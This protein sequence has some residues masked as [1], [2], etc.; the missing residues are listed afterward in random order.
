MT[1]NQ[2]FLNIGRTSSFGVNVR[3][4]F[5][6]MAIQAHPIIALQKRQLKCGSCAKTEHP[7]KSC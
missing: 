7:I 5:T 2:H 3:D 6:C 4:I 1:R